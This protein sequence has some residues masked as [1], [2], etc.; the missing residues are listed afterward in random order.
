MLVVAALNMPGLALL[1]F[2]WS[3]C[4]A[5]LFAVS[6]PR[7]DGLLHMLCTP[8]YMS[9]ACRDNY[10]AAV[11]QGVPLPV[12]TGLDPAAGGAQGQW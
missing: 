9:L 8:C 11:D 7:P 10:L 5:N 1:T 6:C 2:L 12:M 4:Q 3:I